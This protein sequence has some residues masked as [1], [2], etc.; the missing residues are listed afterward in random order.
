VDRISC[1]LLGWLL[2]QNLR[3]FR[4]RPPD[5]SEN[6]I[7]MPFS[8]GPAMYDH[9]RLFARVS[10]ALTSD[11]GLSLRQLARA[12][13]VHS[14]TLAQIIH[15]RTGASF[16][17]W[18]AHRRLVD[19]RRLLS[20]R[21]DLSIKEIAAAAGFSST[22]VFD[23][24]IRRTCGCSPSQCRVN[25]S[26]PLLPAPTDCTCVDA[27]ARPCE[28]PAGSGVNLLDR[29]STNDGALHAKTSGTLESCT[30]SS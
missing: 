24:F 9:D 8:S 2:L 13:H 4:A 27:S 1:D 15:E 14:H 20:T 17:A 7:G 22:A 30:A 18:R 28:R 26:S 23:R 25:E 29:S 6:R 12:H 3:T 21:P 11:P 16:S 19:A 5:S 10:A